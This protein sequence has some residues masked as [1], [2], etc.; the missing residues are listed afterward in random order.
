MTTD[1]QRSSDTAPKWREL[2]ADGRGVRIGTVLAV[3]ILHAGGNY[4]AVTLAPAIVAEVGGGE[5]IGALTALFNITTV[6][7]AAATGPLASRYGTKWLWWI[8]I[9]L[10]LSG[11]LLSAAAGTMQ[12]IASGRALAGFG[13]GGLLALG[14][15]ALRAETTTA[16]FPKISAISGAFWIGADRKSTRLNSSH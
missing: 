4:A 8:M 5:L 12:W 16:A 7:A 6:L 2:L 13:G 14:F 11:A 9:G 10:A 15:V 1:T 3:I